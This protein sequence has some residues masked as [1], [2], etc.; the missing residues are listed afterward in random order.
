MLFLGHEVNYWVELEMTAKK[1]NWDGL[2]EENAKLRAKV[3]KY[4]SLFEQ[5]DQFRG[6]VNNLKGN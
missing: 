1:G 4:E 6:V 3:H 5:A 2:I